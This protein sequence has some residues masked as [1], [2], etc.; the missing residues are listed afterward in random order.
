MRFTEETRVAYADGEL[1]EATRAQ[2]EDA[3]E[4]QGAGVGSKVESR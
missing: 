2:V 3:A 1:D 4:T